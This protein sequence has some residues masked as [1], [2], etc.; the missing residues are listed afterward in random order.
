MLYSQSESGWYWHEECHFNHTCFMLIL[1]DDVN[2]F[3]IINK[4]L[5]CSVVIVPFE[6]YSHDH[7]WNFINDISMS[8][9][10]IHEDYSVVYGKK[11]RLLNFFYLALFDRSNGL[12]FIW[13]YLQQNQSINLRNHYYE[14]LAAVNYISIFM[15]YHLHLR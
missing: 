9:E 6:H 2:W 15:L 10:R 5:C 12:L 4:F 11:C 14:F 3:T 7:V 13:M 8:G 1:Q